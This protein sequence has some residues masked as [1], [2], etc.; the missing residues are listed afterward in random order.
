MSKNTHT[1]P[2]ITIVIPVY[3]V[4]N[5]VEKCINSVCN[6]LY[7]N[8]DIILVDDGSTDSSGRICDRM[9]EQDSRIRVLHTENKGLSAARN[10]GID[11]ARGSLIGFV[12]SDDWVEPDMYSFL[13]QLMAEH[14]ADITVCSHYVDKNGKQKC[15]MQRNELVVCNR[16]EAMELLMIDKLLHNYAWDKLYKKELFDGL[17]YPEGIIYE[18]IAFTFKVMYRVQKVV[19]HA[20]P[21]YHYTVRPGSIVSKRYTIHRNLSYFNAEYILMTF[22]V[23]HGYKNG[24]KHLVRRGIHTLKRLIMSNCPDETLV[25]ILNQLRPYH[26]IGIKEIGL[27]NVWRRYMMENHLQLYKKLY[28]LSKKIFK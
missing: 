24:A 28:R 22:M 25:D 17:R 5:Y 20:Q 23:K 13:Y 26:Y 9:A 2:L 18:D 19:I 8:L 27:A 11:I 3:N 14:N 6:Q 10:A 16:D 15:K 1:L 7:D 12:D 21:K 4:E